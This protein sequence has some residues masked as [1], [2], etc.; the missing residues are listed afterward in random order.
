MGLALGILV[1]VIG[2]GLAFVIMFAGSMR[3]TGNKPED[4]RKAGQVFVF[5]CLVS[6]VLIF[7]HY[8]PIHW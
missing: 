2:I 3:T 8:H 6:A 5:C 4:S 1:F 7:F